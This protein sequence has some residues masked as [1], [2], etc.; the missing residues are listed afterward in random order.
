[1]NMDFFFVPFQKTF[2]AITFIVLSMASVALTSYIASL[3]I[4]A[5]RRALKLWHVLAEAA[6]GANKATALPHNFYATHVPGAL[7]EFQLCIITYDVAMANLSVTVPISS[8]L[9]SISVHDELTRL[10]HL[11]S[12]RDMTDRS[13]TIQILASPDRIAFSWKAFFRMLQSL[14]LRAWGSFGDQ[15]SEDLLVAEHN[16]VKPSHPRGFIV[17]KW[18][19]NGQNA[20][21]QMRQQIEQIVC[22][23]ENAASNQKEIQRDKPEQPKGRG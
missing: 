8:G 13:V 7:S 11:I 12:D 21:L 14:V 6:G 10:I 1:M 9:W 4:L 19:Q 18:L 22:T 16:I 5:R 15:R 3:L 20:S 17:I 23:I 2:M